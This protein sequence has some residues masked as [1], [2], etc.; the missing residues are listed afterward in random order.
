MNIQKMY[1]TT[2]TI[3]CWNQIDFKKA[4]QNVKK[5]Q[6]RIAVAYENHRQDVA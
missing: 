1:A 2:D 6:K 3:T 4:E 5:L